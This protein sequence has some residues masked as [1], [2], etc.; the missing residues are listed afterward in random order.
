L[1]GFDGV[2]GAT[3]SP[4]ES[5]VGRTMTFLDGARLDTAQKKFGLSSLLLDGTSDAVQAADSNDWDFGAG[6]FT[7]ELWVRPGTGFSANE[8]FIGHWGTAA[9]A[10]AWYLYLNAGNLTLRFL[11]TTS[12]Y[13]DTVVA[14]TPVVGTWY[15]IAADRDVNGR[16]RLY[17]NGKMVASASFPQT[18]QNGTGLLGIGSIPGNAAFDMQGNIDEVRITKGVARYAADT[19]FVLPTARFPRS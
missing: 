18:I 16:V 10:Q 19:D 15:H 8:A 5:P 7:V 2:N 12:T 4:D 9:A 13:R 17:V 6:Q 14:W 11:D 3:S 1:M